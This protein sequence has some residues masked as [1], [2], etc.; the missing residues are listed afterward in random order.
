MKPKRIWPA[1]AVA[2]TFVLLA[3]CGSPTHSAAPSAASPLP[4]QSSSSPPP[5]L[6]PSP[7]GGSGVR[8]TTSAAKGTCGPYNY[9]GITGSNGSTTFVLNNMWGA[10]SGT[11]QTLSADSPGSWSVVANAQPAGNTA[12]QTYPDTQQMYTRSDN[13]PDPLSRFGSIISSFTENL[14]AA[15]GTSAEAAYDIWIGQNASTNYADEVMIWNDQVNRGTCGGATVKANADFGGSNGIPRQNWT[16]CDY[17][18]SELIWY[19]TGSNEQSG[20]VDVLS[21]LTWLEGH[22]YLPA[23]SGLNQIDYGFEICST[24]GAKTFTVSR[25]AIKSACNSGASC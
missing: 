12:V 6:S 2:V 16:L 5:D 13:T 18:G 3:G 15:S 19:L 9:Q 17:R 1:I 8:C 24:T 25:Y 11:T 23:G 21:M 10:N 22:G 4:S 14:N 20:A 7:S